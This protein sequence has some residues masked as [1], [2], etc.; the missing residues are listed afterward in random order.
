MTKQTRKGFGAATGP[1]ILL[2]NDD[3]IF[4]EGL[5]ALEE[6]LSAIAEVIVVAPDR[7][8]SAVSH[9]LTIRHPLRATPVAPRRYAV[10]GTPT[11]CVNLGVLHLLRRHPPDLVVSGINFGL[12]LGDDVTYSGT[13]SAAF[14]AS[15]RGIPSI[16]VSQ[17]MGPGMTFER[18]ARFARHVAAALLRARGRKTPWI[19]NLNVPLGAP[20]GVEITK[21]GKRE[22]SASVVQKIDPRGEKYF[23]IGQI[24][25]GR[26][27][28]GTDFSAIARDLISIT[29]L[30][31]DLTAYSDL[32]DVGALIAPLEAALVAEPPAVRRK[33]TARPRRAG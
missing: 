4:S 25:P 31:L 28:P 7:E 27:E 8:Q 14:E 24:A 19:L 6:S 21:L 32:A 33:P 11:D 22:L 26:P 12:N 18:A 1:R 30:H 23:W 16:A 20:K 10:D 17:A 5:R 9:A 3:G 29:P 15:L 2:T 13:V